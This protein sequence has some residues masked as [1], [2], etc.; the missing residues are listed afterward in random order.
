MLSN[1]DISV[2][3][4]RY[5]PHFSHHPGLPR[6]THTPAMDDMLSFAC[7]L[8]FSHRCCGALRGTN[9]Q[10]LVALAERTTELRVAPECPGVREEA[11]HQLVVL[12]KA[13]P[14]LRHLDLRGVGISAEGLTELRTG[15]SSF[16]LGTKGCTDA[17][18]IT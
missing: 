8:S 4:H 12:L 11:W 18:L 7:L 9:R 15:M 3:F 6:A 1:L 17:R 16:S 10:L 14:N 5:V 13:L 2:D